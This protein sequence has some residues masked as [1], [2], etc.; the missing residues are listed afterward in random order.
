MEIKKIE[1][2][3]IIHNSQ[4]SLTQN[5][6]NLI[7]FAME[8]LDIAYAPYSRFRVG[9]AVRLKDGS[10][11]AGCNQE[12]AS[13]PLCMCGERVALYNA[14]VYAPNI[15]P[16]TLAIVIKNEKKPITTPVSPCGACRQVISEFE[17][18]FKNPIRILLTSD[19]QTIYE[20]QSVQDILPL[21]FDSGFL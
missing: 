9:A 10:I 15:A 11:Y 6:R 2:S 19:G 14:A 18:R 12:N 1:S 8:Q 21:S 13:Y 7:A 5:D 16:E 3:Y 4:E 20:L 17:Q